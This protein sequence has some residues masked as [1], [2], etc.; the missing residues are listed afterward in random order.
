M[1]SLNINIYHMV[2]QCSEM[3]ANIK[4]NITVFNEHLFDVYEDGSTCEKCLQ[5]FLNIE[6][7]CDKRLCSGWESLC[8]HK[9]CFQLSLMT[10]QH[11][12]GHKHYL[13]R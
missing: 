10:L 4:Y 2:V 9:A 11:L 13:L 1:P 3:F 8:S 7:P 12:F 5:T 6:Q